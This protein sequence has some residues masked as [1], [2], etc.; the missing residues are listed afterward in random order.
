MKRLIIAAAMLLA[1]AGA[2]AQNIPQT[3]YGSYVEVN[4]VA[5][6]EVEPNRIYLAIT[7]NEQ[8]SKGRVTVEEQERKMLE[9]LRSLGIDVK[10]QLRV[11]D[12]TSSAIKRTKAVTVK[13]YQLLLTDTSLVGEVYASLQQAGITAI[14]IEKVSHSDLEALRAEVRNEAM[15]NA[16]TTAAELAEAVGQTIG[17]AFYINYYNN[18]A[19][20][21][22]YR[23]AKANVM[24]ANADGVAESFDVDRPEFRK[25]KLTATVT[26][27]FVLE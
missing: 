6:R 3:E 14:E 7:V 27:K 25:I 8:D 1:V 4:G 10:T 11:S 2:G 23:T 12:I 5:E 16:R 9:V 26:A 22:L 17:K 15:R 18:F 13:N 19:Q 24:M 21:T 20:P